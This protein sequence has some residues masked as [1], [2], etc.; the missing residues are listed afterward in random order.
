[1]PRSRRGSPPRRTAA[2]AL[3][4]AAALLAGSAGCSGPP[5]RPRAERPSPS[6][7]P[8]PAWD[9]SPTSLA[10]VG[11]SIT[12]SFNACGV[13]T[14]C[15]PTSWATGSD[16]RVDSLARRL[17]GAKALASRTWNV[18]ESGSRMAALPGQM[19]RA[20][21]H[22]PGLVT[23]LTGANDACRAD[24]SVMTPVAEYRASFAESLRTLRA[25]SPKSQVYVAS[26]PDLRRLWSTG[27]DA[28]LSRQIWKL[29]LC[30]SMLGGA[31]DTGRAAE[32][33]RTE[34]YQRVVAYN[35]ALR[36]V[37]AKDR[38]CRY[39]DGAVFD[40]RFT[41][42]QLSPFDFFH[43]SRDGQAKLAEIAYRRVTA[44]D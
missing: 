39:D 35:Q 44:Q 30:P 11:D 9:T 6:P 17:L 18:A 5:E 10:A 20:A 28:P 12:R 27:R 40:Y 7:R 23:V 1:M 32:R 29:G 33:R 22:R 24:V 16:P 8:S 13:L 14:D 36:E 21:A 43:P 26:V 38:L 34:V 4:A 15:P 3:T 37:C 42:A 19:S 41:G 25:A 2:V 31:E